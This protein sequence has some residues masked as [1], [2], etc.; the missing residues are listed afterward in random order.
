MFKVETFKDPVI[1]YNQ[2]EVGMD[3]LHI[4]S[5]ST[6]AM[7]MKGL[8]KVRKKWNVWIYHHF[9]NALYPVWTDTRTKLEQQRLIRKIIK[10]HKEEWGEYTSTLLRQVNRINQTFRGLLELNLTTLIDLKDESEI[11]KYYK[12]IY[13]YFLQQKEVSKYI[14]ELNKPL[15]PETLDRCLNHYNTLR[16]NIPREGYPSVKRIYI[17]SMDHMEMERL[18]FLKKLSEAGYE[19][20]F[21]IPYSE[22]Y[23]ILHSPW[24]NVYKHFVPQEQWQPIQE[25][26][27]EKTSPL[28]N[29]LS[30]KEEAAE[31][32]IKLINHGGI[33]A[34]AFKKYLRE[35]PLDKVDMEYIGGQED[36]LNEYFRDEIDHNECIKHFYETPLGRF[37]SELYKLR[38]EDHSIMMNYPTFITMMTSG[39]VVLLNDNKVTVSGKDALGL[40]NELKSY[41]VGVKTLEDIIGRLQAYKKFEQKSDEL[42]LFQKEVIENNK[43]KGF[44]LNPLKAFGFSHNDAYGITEDQLLNLALQLKNIIN[45]LLIEASPINNIGNH[46]E[47]FKKLLQESQVLTYIEDAA[48]KESY[49][50]FFKVLNLQLS[51]IVVTDLED[52]SEY[53][54]AMTSVNPKEMEELADLKDLEDE[55]DG[56][57]LVLIKG[58]E[59]I[60]GM[61][62]NGVKNLYLCDLSTTNVNTYV[63]TREKTVSLFSLEELSTYIMGMENSPHKMTLI[64]A[65]KI[66]TACQKEVQNFIKYNMATLLTY[67]EGNLHIGWIKNLNAYD[68]KWYLLEIIESLYKTDEL[69]EE[70]SKLEEEFILSVEERREEEPIEVEHLVKELSPL[71][72]RDLEECGK[73]FYYNNI[74]YPHPIYR[75]DFTQRYAFARACR[76]LE[77]RFMGEEN[78]KR[79][80]YPLFPQWTDTLKDNLLIVDKNNHRSSGN[81]NMPT[82]AEFEDVRFANDMIRMQYLWSNKNSTKSKTEES[83]RKDIEKWA[84]DSKVSLRTKGEHNCKICP[85]ELLCSDAKLSTKREV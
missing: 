80:L 51:K 70:T 9:Y 63:S 11:T 84:K 37:V 62:V 5:I 60:C 14:E 83:K 58:L 23:S 76:I 43:V 20:I 38:I 42:D 6:L 8:G 26:V 55:E 68:T 19:V 15:T 46:I 41:M 34:V 67:Y 52:I 18:M 59:Y 78:M 72:L 54:V 47:V 22:E 17:Y 16:L 73:R 71:A 79:M 49:I 27:V 48:T 65:H 40:L 31:G 57:P 66:A 64:K 24:L 29:F 13:T 10:E 39:I 81:R 4:T 21:R 28:K 82:Y 69:E 1:F 35:H 25:Q 30:G 85:Y 2:I 56:K 44:L 77:G 3:E 50:N 32:N 33:D 45:I 12:R 74:L 53:I 36:L 61:N 75:E 7:H